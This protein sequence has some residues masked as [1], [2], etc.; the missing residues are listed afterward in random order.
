MGTKIAVALSGTALLF[1]P[2]LA[3]QV[4][5]TSD[6]ATDPA[7]ATMVYEHVENFA[8]ALRLMAEGGDTAAILQAEYLDRASPA[9]RMYVEDHDVTAETLLGAI[10]RHPREYAALVDLP[11]RLADQEPIF[12]A[13]YARLQELI[14][15][16]VFPPTHFVVGVWSGASEASEFGQLISVERPYTPERKVNTLVHELVHVQQA[17]AQGIDT[18]Q[19]LYG[20]GP[21]RSL[22]ALAI[23]E[24]T[25][26]FLANLVVEG[27][28]HEPVVRYV[29]EHEPELWERFQAE[30]AHRDPGYW[31][32]AEPFAEGEPRDLGYA[33]GYRIVQAFYERVPDK[34]QA[35]REILGVTDYQAFLERSGYRDRFREP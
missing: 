6:L 5:I 14:P 27:F 31:M 12:R 29:V 3:G 25:A 34:A 32:W 23:R 33:M 24:G 22:L 30:M 9:L 35:I 17:F 2:P 10:R 7:R 28:T 18:Y 15:N 8:R 4:E 11:D 26:D 16:A 20:D 21:N 1:V 19:S 13:S